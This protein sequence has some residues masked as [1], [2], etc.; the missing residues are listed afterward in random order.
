MRN[1]YT[2]PANE[3]DAN[4]PF[5]REGTEVK[6]SPHKPSRNPGD[7]VAIMDRIVDG[8]PVAKKGLWK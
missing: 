4:D 6:F 1:S 7:L 8:M 5:G 2:F 3:W